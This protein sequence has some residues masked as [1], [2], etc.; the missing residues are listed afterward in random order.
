MLIMVRPNS[1]EQEAFVE[2]PK[3]KKHVFPR[4]FG[5]ETK[6][7]NVYIWGQ[8]YPWQPHCARQYSARPEHQYNPLFFHWVVLPTRNSYE[9]LT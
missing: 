7:W 6:F 5:S 8:Q 2:K 4:A 9:S 3:T 1:L